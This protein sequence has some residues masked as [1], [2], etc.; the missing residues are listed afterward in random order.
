MFLPALRGTMNVTGR[1]ATAA[2]D[3]CAVRSLTEQLAAP[4]GPEDQTVQ[5]MPDVS[6]TKWH[7]AHTTWFFETFVLEPLAP[8]YPRVR[9]ALPGASS[10]RYYEAVGPQQ[11]PHRAGP[12]HPARHRG[13]RRATAATSTSAMLDLLDGDVAPELATLVELGLPPRAAAPGAAGDGH[14]ARAVVQP[15]APGV[16][17]AAVGATAHQP[18]GDGWIEHDGGIV[19]IGHDGDG[20]AFDNEGPRHDALLQPFAIAD[21]ARDVRRLAGVHRRRWLPPPRAVDVRRLGTRSRTAGWERP[22]LLGARRRLVARVHAGRPAARSTRPR[23]STTSAGT[24]PTPTPAGPAPACRPRPSGRSPRRS[25]TTDAPAAGT[26]RCGSGRRARTTPTPASS[27]RPA[28]SASTTASSW[29]TSRCSG[30]APASPPPATPGATY[31]NFFPA[32]ARWMY[33]GLRLAR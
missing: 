19:E 31:R 4:L 21:G 13:G 2:T 17:P 32:S 14:Q 7:R 27:P 5:S 23:R 12:D 28:R 16:R 15:A 22:R 18:A 20:F 9:R 33:G 11:P 10:T 29:S 30:A 24:R 25:P 6:P 3:Y 1:P 26:A 8:G